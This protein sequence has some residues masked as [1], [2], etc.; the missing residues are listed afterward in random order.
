[1]E[2]EGVRDD[3]AVTILGLREQDSLACAVDMQ[4]AQPQDLGTYHPGECQDKK[5][6]SL[7]P[8]LGIPNASRRLL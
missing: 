7:L 2:F 5:I 4:P 8:E 1:M 6:F 3:A